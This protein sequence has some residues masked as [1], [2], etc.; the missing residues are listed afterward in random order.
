MIEVDFN[1]MEKPEPLIERGC[2]V[3]IDCSYLFCVLDGLGYVEN[4]E[5]KPEVL[6]LLQDGHLQRADAT[7]AINDGRRER[8]PRI[9]Y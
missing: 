5:L 7:A 2:G 9:I 6:L 3:K 1:Q 8:A 4:G